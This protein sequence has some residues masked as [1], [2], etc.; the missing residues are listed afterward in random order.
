MKALSLHI[1][2][3]TLSRHPILAVLLTG[4]TYHKESRPGNWISQNVKLVTLT[5]VR[6][7]PHTFEQQPVSSQQ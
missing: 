2:S 4:G 3:L 7:D 5:L 1:D 6:A